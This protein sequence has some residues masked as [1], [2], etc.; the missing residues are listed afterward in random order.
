[1]GILLW[2][3]LGGMAGWVASMIM[4]TNARMGALANIIVGMLGSV[5]GGWIFNYFGG[6]GIT[7]FNLYSFG[8]ALVGA[9]VLLFVAKIAIR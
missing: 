3:V 4:G 6:F 2:I 8:V 9:C 5:I 1:M 7:G